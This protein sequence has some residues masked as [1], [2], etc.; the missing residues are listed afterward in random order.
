MR[1]YVSKAKTLLS[2]LLGIF[3]LLFCIGATWQ[4]LHRPWPSWDLNAMAARI[5]LPLGIPCSAFLLVFMVGQFM[6]KRPGLIIDETGVTATAGKVG[7]VPW[8]EIREA[9]VVENRTGAAKVY[10]LLLVLK[11][12]GS[13]SRLFSGKLLK[14]HA[15]NVA[16]FGGLPIFLQP[17]ILD[18]K[19][20]AEVID[21]YSRAQIAEHASESVY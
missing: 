7:F 2:I 8:S 17:F 4:F 14:R 5:I 9:K 6:D 10:R 12:S 18:V 16:M 19:A 13:L 21:E 1:L 11:D 15:Y 3:M 20:F